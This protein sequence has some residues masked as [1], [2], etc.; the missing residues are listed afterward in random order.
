MSNIYVIA[1]KTGLS[2]STVARALSG[3]GY[4]SQKARQTVLEMAEKLH[5][6]PTHA[7]RSLKSKRTEKVLMCVPDIYNPFYFK[8]IQGANDVLEQYGYFILL[9]HTKHSV[10]QELKMIRSLTERYGDGM[11]L[12][13]FDFNEKNLAAIRDCPLPIVLTNKYGGEKVMDNFDYVYVDD[14]KG[15][16]LATQ[17]LIGQGHKKIALIVGS[18]AEQ[19]G[20]ERAEGFS[21]A[22][23]DGGLPVPAGSVVQS[24]YTRKG[25][26]GSAE[27]L[28]GG[29]DRPTAIVC[30]NDLM[31]IGCMDSCRARG[32]RIPGDV[33]V[34]S[35]DNTDFCTC[36]SPTLSSID[37]QQEELGRIAATLLMERIDK[38][39]RL[40]ESV[41]LE[42]EL[43]VR[44]SSVTPQ[45]R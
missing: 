37:M 21:A 38:K 17:H 11:I 5:Y 10:A 45:R 32:I 3:R 29:K 36:T 8:M 26:Y 42:P 2:P 20:K 28:L 34:V 27:K 40:K 44:Q 16:Y 1:E 19:T 35:M 9:C 39:R 15:I 22:M 13:S 31:A 18:T 23:K 33:A 4:C 25:G 43:V 6:T 7:A 12:V 41:C 14:T 24:D 30:A